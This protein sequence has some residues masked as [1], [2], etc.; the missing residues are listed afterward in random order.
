[1]K[2][3][4]IPIVFSFDQ[5]MEL[6]AGVC[7]T[8]LLENAHPTTIYDIY[9]L[10]ADNCSFEKSRINELISVYGNCRI[11]YRSVGKV[12]E[13]AFEVRGITVATY[14]RLLI[15][16]IIPE[17]DKI[18]Y[19]D[20]DV[21][22]RDDLSSIYLHTDMDGYY[23][24]GVSTPYSDITTYVKKIIGVEISEYICAGNLMM[25]SKKMRDDKVVTEFKRVAAQNWLYQDQDTLNLVCRGKIKLLAPSFGLVNT[26][27]EILSDSTQSYYSEEQRRYAL[28]YGILHYNG[29]KPW[30]QTCLNLDIW[31]EYYRRSIFFDEKFYHDFFYQLVTDYDRLSLSKRIKIMIRYFRNGRLT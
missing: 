15:P 9:I 1:M 30:K 10:H 3:N 6:A 7:I 23:I 16:E 21:I 26:L 2:K 8:S 4:N 31:W 19:S 20:V 22:F 18:I 5:Q 28:Q 17:Y 11:T 25:N 27:H 14:Y 13:S 29:P 12:F 24:A